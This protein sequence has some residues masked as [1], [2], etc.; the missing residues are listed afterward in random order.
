MMLTSCR[1][2]GNGK[3]YILEYQNLGQWINSRIIPTEDEVSETIENTFQTEY[4]R[5]FE[6][7]STERKDYG[8][9]L[10]RWVWYV[11][12]K[13]LDKDME[14]IVVMEEKDGSYKT[15]SAK[16]LEPIVIE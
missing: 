7:I 4:G 9:G 11:L 2:T 8:T 14:F 10:P 13:D 3:T 1:I 15:Y 12:V 16:N 5:E 6:V